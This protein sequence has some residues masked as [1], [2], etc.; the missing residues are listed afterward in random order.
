VGK[1]SNLYKQKI[2]SIPRTIK[3]N[4]SFEILDVE[5]YEDVTITTS[6][7][8]EISRLSQSTNKI[9]ETSHRYA[10]FEPDYFLLD[11]SF[12]IPPKENQG[13]SEV[14]WWS[15]VI[16]DANG[17]FLTRP[18]LEFTFLTAHSSIGLTITFDKQTNEYAT[19]FIID[20]YNGSDGLISSE[21]VTGNNNPVYLYENSLDGYQKVVITILKWVNP[22][23]RARIIEVDF[24]I[25]RE[26]S[27]DKLISLRLIEEMDPLAST[28]PSNEMEFVLDNSDNEFNI[29]N[30]NGVYR[31]LKP[32]QEMKAR[33]GLL[34][35][36]ERYEYIDMG[37]YFL[38]EWTVEE[39]GMTSTFVGRDIF[40]M[41]DAV[42]YTNFLQN[43][44]LYD[45][46]VDVLTQANV[47]TYQIDEALKEITTIGFTETIVAREALQMIAMAGRSVIRQDRQG[48]I[49]IEQIEQLA[50]ET[51]Y[52]T[53][54]GPDNFAGMTT[55]QVYQDY[56]F[57]AIDFDTAYKV[58]QIKL[59]TAVTHLIFIINDGFGNSSEYKIVNSQVMKGQGF[60][61]DNPLINSEAHALEVAEY[62]FRE[63]SYIAE[64]QANWR[65]NPAL[66]VGDI[67]LVEDSY[68]NKKKARLTKQEFE[69][70]GYLSGVS[71]AKGGI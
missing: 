62:M 66:E 71:E 41:L 44:N 57:Q 15:D 67:V 47:K 20:V 60:E 64:Y 46:A 55:P 24:G 32:N 13:D 43:T 63:Y 68:N 45:L 49:I 30:P 54:T 52:L 50:I 39:G 29:L 23:R 5:A 65:Q 59:G 21:T 34:I 42:E 14:G 25:V 28:V 17:D 26:Y 48:A 19:D 38:D 36:D 4:V 11:G 53:F 12:R 6:D 61:I 70:A 22:N 10:T 8:S 3:A 33:L 27:G 51:G 18:S 16:S 35:G 7:E 1:V 56:S 37:K 9:R 58:P 40:T 2:Y 69:Y 31:F